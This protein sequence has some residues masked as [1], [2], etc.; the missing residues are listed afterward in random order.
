[1]P[2]DAIRGCR[3][4]HNE[5]LHK[6]F[7]GTVSVRNRR[8]RARKTINTYKILVK[9]LRGRNQSG[10]TDIGENNIKMDLREIGCE[11]MG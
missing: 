11:E 9:D 6:T 5:E 3:Y 10:D 4:W 7:N 1:V 8:T 2:E